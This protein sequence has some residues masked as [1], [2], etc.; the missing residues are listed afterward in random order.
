MK[1]ICLLLI[2]TL[3]AAFPA[4]A[5]EEENS[6]GKKETIALPRFAALRYSE[7][8]LRTGPGTRYPIEWVY[9]RAGMPVEII[10][11][12]DLWYRI[13]DFEGAEGW[14]HKT[15]LRMDRRGMVTGQIH[16]LRDDPNEK[17]SIAAHL[18]PGVIFDIKSCAPEWCKARGKNFSGYLRKSDFFGAY[19]QEKFD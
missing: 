5:D 8:N 2:L 15:K 1:S 11:A 12:F 9:R 19:P 6:G 4:H 17:A 7:V 18:E 3:F 14:V 16:E 10:A 13:R